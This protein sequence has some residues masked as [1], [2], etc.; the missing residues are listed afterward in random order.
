MFVKRLDHVNV[1]TPRFRETIEFYE[2]VL[3][4]RSGPGAIPYGAFVFD[5]SGTACIHVVEASTDSLDFLLTENLAH[6][7]RAETDPATGFATLSGGGAIDHVA[8]ICEGLLTTLER[9]R[10]LGEPH[11]YYFVERQRVHQIFL[12]D[13]NGIVL[14]LSFFEEVAPE[15]LERLNRGVLAVDRAP[16]VGPYA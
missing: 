2:R 16:A 3:D 11:R 10:S 9:L 15:A 7:S 14:E 6:R 4:M 1:L 5:A 13:P 12:R 8:L